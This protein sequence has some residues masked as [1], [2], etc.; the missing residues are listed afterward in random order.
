MLDSNI[1]DC[2]SGG[3]AAIGYKPL[4]TVSELVYHTQTRCV[5]VI[6]RINVVEKQEQA[7]HTSKLVA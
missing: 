2:R 3:L 5:H 1:L 6:K 7:I 4:R